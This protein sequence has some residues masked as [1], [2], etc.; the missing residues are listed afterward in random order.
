MQ[1]EVNANFLDEAVLKIEDSV[2]WYADIV[3]FLV[4]KQFSKDFN[5]QQKNKLMHD[6]KFYYWD[7]PQLFKHEPNHIFRLVSLRL[8]SLITFSGLCP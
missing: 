1:P 5:A 3:N 8:H 2:H 7:E 4:C 6:V